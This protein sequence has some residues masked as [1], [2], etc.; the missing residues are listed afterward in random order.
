MAALFYLPTGGAEVSFSLHPHQQFSIASPGIFSPLKKKKN[1][2]NNSPPNG[3][4]VIPQ[5]F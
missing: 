5:W 3:Y 1:Y 4:E 2:N